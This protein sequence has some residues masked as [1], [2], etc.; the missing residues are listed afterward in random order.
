MILHIGT[1]TALCGARVPPYLL[2]TSAAHADCVD[3]LAVRLA[4]LESQIEQVK[5]LIAHELRK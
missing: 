4:T 1:D 3:C 2:V 5:K